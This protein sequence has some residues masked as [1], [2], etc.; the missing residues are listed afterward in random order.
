VLTQVTPDIFDTPQTFDFDFRNHSTP[1]RDSS[2]LSKMHLEYPAVSHHQVVQ[3]KRVE[4]LLPS[5]VLV[6]VSETHRLEAHELGTSDIMD[7]TL[8]YNH[9]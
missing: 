3:D 5:V 9:P 8:E 7:A 4:M 6:S 1:V 2:D